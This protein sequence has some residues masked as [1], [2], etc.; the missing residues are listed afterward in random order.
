MLGGELVGFFGEALNAGLEVGATFHSRGDV[1]GFRAR[2]FFTIVWPV[3]YLGLDYH[4]RASAEAG[5][6]LKVPL[7]V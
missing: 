7:R 3:V 1:V 6:L 4:G 2:G 5:L